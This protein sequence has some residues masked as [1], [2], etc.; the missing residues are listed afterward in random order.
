MMMKVLVVSGLVVCE[1]LGPV[2]DPVLG[3]L[4]AF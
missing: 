2:K 1:I 3:N 4:S